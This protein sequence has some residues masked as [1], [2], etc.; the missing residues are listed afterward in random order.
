MGSYIFRTVRPDNLQA[1][2]KANFPASIRGTA[3]DSWRAY[4][5][6]QGATGNTLA[7]LEMSFTGG[8]KSAHDAW[9]AKISGATG[10][11]TKEKARSMYK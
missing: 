2:I 1:Y 4:L 8:S 6:S 11:T 9:A 7:D 10:A 3:N 5:I